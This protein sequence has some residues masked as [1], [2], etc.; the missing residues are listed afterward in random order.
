MAKISKDLGAGTLHPRE[1]IYLSGLL[2]AAGS[3][4]IVAADGAASVS[5]DLRGTFSLTVE[6]AGSVDGVNWLIIPVRPVNAATLAYL[7]GITGSAAGV[8][9]GKCAQYRFIRVRVSS[10]ISGAAVATLAADPAA[11]DDSIVGTITPA[12][13]TAVGTVGAGLTLTLPQQGP[14]LRHYIT[15]LSINRFAAA[16][17]T[18][19]A[20]PVTLTTT[21]LPGSLA[22]TFAADALP[23]GGLDRWRED[24]A[25]PLATLTPNTATTIVCPAV[26]G[27]IW[28]MTA[29]FYVGP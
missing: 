20:A 18:A 17:L 26:T 27:V 6:V 28:R 24:F 1:T 7:V 25:F 14:S 2:G 15:Y 13:V 19:A 9:V 21:N 3:E 12:L 4:I 8:F 29:G 11:I 16:A 23:L 22:F 10:Y 5:L